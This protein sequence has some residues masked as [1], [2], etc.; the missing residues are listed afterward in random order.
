MENQNCFTT[1]VAANGRFGF[2]QTAPKEEV[3]HVRCL[4]EVNSSLDMSA[5]ELVVETTIDDVIIGLLVIMTIEE[6]IQLSPGV[7]M[8]IEDT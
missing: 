7:N 2:L 3:F 4:V 5:V 8:M 6:V 1:G